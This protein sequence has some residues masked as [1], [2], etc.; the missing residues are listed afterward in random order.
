MKITKR[1]LKQ[2][3]REEY[4]RIMVENR[5]GRLTLWLQPSSNGEDLE[6]YVNESDIS[7]NL[8]K[9]YDQNLNY[10]EFLSEFEE[11]HGMPMPADARVETSAL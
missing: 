3:I 8:G 11:D 2:I 1:Q 6:I 7:Y 9:Y 10:G 4:K 5:S